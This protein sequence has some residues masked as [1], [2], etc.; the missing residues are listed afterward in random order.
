MK[1][2]FYGD[3]FCAQHGPN[4]WVEK[5]TTKLNAEI[6][7]IGSG[8]SSVWDAVINQYLK[9]EP[10]YGQM[11]GKTHSPNW[12]LMPDILVFCW[13]DSSRLFHKSVRFL[14]V[15]SSKNTAN[16]INKEILVAAQ[17]YYEHLY[18]QKKHNIEYMALLS[19]FDQNILSK[20]NNRCKIIHMWS[21]CATLSDT[22]SKNSVYAYRWQHGVEI[23]PALFSISK[24][25]LDS[26]SKIT[27]IN[28]PRPNHLGSE[29]NNTMIANW[30]LDAIDNYESGRLVDYTDQF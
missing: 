12:E 29:E 19:W 11:M 25:E 14:S 23:R 27:G 21:F 4:T 28:D 15:Y 13:T 10:S 20:I 18:D 30:V 5:I 22:I 17:Q 6:T 7:N 3:S 24:S 1:I 16:K 2:G 9:N 26:K 8:G